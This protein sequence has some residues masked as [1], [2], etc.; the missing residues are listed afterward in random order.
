MT[1]SKVLSVIESIKAIQINEFG[2]I[3]LEHKGS[4]FAK[5]LLLAVGIEYL[6][7]CLDELPF[8]EPNESEKRFNRAIRK[9][10]DKKYHK[11]ANKSA[12]V[13]LYKDF[14]CCFVHRIKPGKSIVIS[15]LDESKRERTKHLE[16]VVGGPLVLVLEDFYN[17]YEKACN[18]LIRGY[19][20]GKYTNKKG[21][22]EYLQYT[23]IR[24]NKLI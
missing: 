23:S 12:I 22:Q 17:D 21:D 4:A 20:N 7:A 11:H 13:Y 1:Y 14:R 6:G 18:R 15:H 8:N 19:E 24:D 5:F 2:S 3:I 9:L 16:H 10:F